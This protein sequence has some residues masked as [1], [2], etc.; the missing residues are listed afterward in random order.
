MLNPG[1][2]ADR[3]HSAARALGA[4]VPFFLE[5]GPALASG[6]GDQFTTLPALR[7]GWL[8]IAVPLIIIPGKTATLYGAL[9]PRDFSDGARIDRVAAT[10]SAGEE[11]SSEDLGNAFQRPLYDRWP[12]AKIVRDAMLDAGARVV[13]LSGAGPAHYAI[14]DDFH[15]A[16]T[17]AAAVRTRL[18]RA[19]R[20]IVCRPLSEPMGRRFVV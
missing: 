10:L 2:D 18:D 16:A 5:S 14:C 11:L 20:L 8:V 13:A 4:D 9:T 3:I 7:I 15:A 17:L 6:R 19:T 12:A 1:I